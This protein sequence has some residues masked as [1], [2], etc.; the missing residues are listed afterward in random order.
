M[1]EAVEAYNF[2]SKD[3]QIIPLLLLIDLSRVPQLQTAT[4][5]DIGSG[6]LWLYSV[7]REST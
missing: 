5:F 3:F 2:H 1:I 7:Q 4:Y 6:P